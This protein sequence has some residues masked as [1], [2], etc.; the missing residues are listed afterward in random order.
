MDNKTD[1]FFQ[2][3]HFAKNSVLVKIVVIA[4]LIL[5][6]MIPKSMIVSL[7]DEREARRNCTIVEIESK[8]GNEQ[9]IAGPILTVPFKTFSKGKN[10]K[11]VETIEYAHFLPDELNIIGNIDPVVRYRGIYKAILYNSQITLNGSFSAP[12][13]NQLQKIPEENILFKDAF[14]SIGITDLR[15]IKER[16]FIQFGGKA[17]DLEPG[18]KFSGTLN[19]ALSAKVFFKPTYDQKDKI[20]FSIP[21][22]LNGSSS[23][24]F[25]PVGKDTTVQMKSK[26]ADPSFSGAFLPESR[27]INQGGFNA[28][29]KINYLNRSYPQ[30]WIGSDIDFKSSS[31]GV[32]LLLPVDT[33]QKISRTAKYA[34]MFI[35]LTFLT[36]FIIE[37]LFNIRVHP[38]QYLLIGL[39][40]CL[41]YSL[42][43]SLSE[44][45][46]FGSAYLVSSLGV[47]TMIMFYTYSVAKRKHLAALVGLIIMTLY[48]FLYI[49][50]QLQDYSLLIGNLGFFVI[51]SVVMYVTRNID[52]YSIGGKDE[53]DLKTDR[54]I[55]EIYESG[56]E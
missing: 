22:N 40:L 23:L 53:K 1:S 15:G 6:L 50:L 4:F 48:G 7:V 52:W 5:L 8:W 9:L 32:E 14:V 12:A 25:L 24:N 19:S 54:S 29:W 26:W 28:L 47:F 3:N 56:S 35:A 17:I 41:F 36:F 38:I 27:T 42:L 2:V 39:A 10:N 11:V 44:H 16:I 34:I 46:W 51:L 13:F 21:I 20:D 49:L 18:G 45:V 55:E 33:Y 31:F 43:L 30:Q 37:I